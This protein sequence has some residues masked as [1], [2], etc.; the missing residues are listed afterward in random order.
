MGRVLLLVLLLCRA[1][2]AEEEGDFSLLNFTKSPLPRVAHTVNIVTGDWI[3]QASHQETSGPDPYIVGHSYVSSS[4][5]QGSLA[6]GWDFFHPSTLEVYQG[7]GIAYV[8]KSPEICP[9]E[10]SQEI[11]EKGHHHH[12]SLGKP[13]KPP[14]GDKPI[15]YPFRDYIHQNEATLVY[16]EAGGST[17]F[18]KGDDEAKP[19]TP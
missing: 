15:A 3:D 4:S 12:P 7:K 11:I 13:T 14:E 5:E 8:L 19:F 17:Y 9:G 1:L 6:S 2:H 18:F 16:R 10:F